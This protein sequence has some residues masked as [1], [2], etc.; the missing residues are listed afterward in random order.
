MTPT[1]VAIVALSLLMTAAG[2]RAV[3]HLRL[4]WGAP[5]SHD[6]TA[7]LVR[8]IRATIL[9]ACC[10]I[11]MAAVVR[12]STT[13]LILGVIILLEELYETGAVLL[14]LRSERPAE[15]AGQTT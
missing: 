2:L 8:A 6:A 13:L 12:S 14:I 11:F 9:V 15:K 5:D 10:S 3:H 4:V 1:T 7:H